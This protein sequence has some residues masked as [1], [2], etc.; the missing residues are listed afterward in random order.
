MKG[1]M[2][3]RLAL[4]VVAVIASGSVFTKAVKKVTPEDLAIQKAIAHINSQDLKDIHFISC[5]Y[6][7][8]DNEC[9]S[10]TFKNY[11]KN[12]HQMPSYKTE[13]YKHKVL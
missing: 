1:T 4:A 11:S 7:V 5:I 3:R 9:L 10:G 8:S 12:Y 2:Y 13:T 6:K